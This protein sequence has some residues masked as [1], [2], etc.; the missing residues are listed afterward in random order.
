M[1]F[2]VPPS[3]SD[4][5]TTKTEKYLGMIVED[6]TL[7]AALYE[8]IHDQEHAPDILCGHTVVNIS[9][10]SPQNENGPAVVSILDKKTNQTRKVTTRLLV[11]ADGVNSTVR[12]LV[13][14]G[15]YGKGYGQTALVCTVITSAH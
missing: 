9:Y 4:D 12:K 3:G 7:Q 15:Q 11:G 6:S 10:L 14:W 8:S 5:A 2:Q 1:R 13:G